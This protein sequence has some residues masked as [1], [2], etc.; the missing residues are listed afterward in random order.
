MAEAF[1]AHLPQV[2]RAIL[3]KEDQN[4]PICMEDYGTIPSASG[5]IERAVRLPCNHV[6]G[7][8]CI[9]VWLTPTHGQRGN[10]TCPVCRRVLFQI[11]RVP[12][13]TGPWYTEHMRIHGLLR[14][15]ILTLG[16]RLSLSTEAAAVA[17]G[18]ANRIHD[19]GL[20]DDH[21][22]LTV[23]AVSLYMASSAMDDPRSL[24]AIFRGHGIPEVEDVEVPAVDRTLI[25]ICQRARLLLDEP[26]L[27]GITQ[28]ALEAILN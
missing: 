17:V 15:R 28:S 3:G 12:T 4:C 6:V 14:E 1:L 13:R 22:P 11:E 19:R 8:E 25:V 20:T 18:I 26:L 23:V 2:S 27:Q 7:S 24:E 5:I 21:S 9:S 10:N 16:Y